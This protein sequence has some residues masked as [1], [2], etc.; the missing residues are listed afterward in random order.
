M[1]SEISFANYYSLT[2]DLYFLYPLK[3]YI[4][5]PSPGILQEE[6]NPVKDLGF[7]G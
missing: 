2:L 6:V 4:L 5:N 7:R 3:A 1:S